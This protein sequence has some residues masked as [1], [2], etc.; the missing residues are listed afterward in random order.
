[1]PKTE[2]L[3][4]T[5][6]RGKISEIRNALQDLSLTLRTLAEFPGLVEPEENGA[7]YADNALLKAKYYSSKTGLLTVADD[8]G[9]EVN[10]INGR[11]G[12]LSARYGGPDATDEDRVNLLLGELKGAADRRA[13]FVC[14]MALEGSIRTVANGV[15]R[16]EIAEAALGEGGFGYDPIFIPDGYSETFGVLP[17][18]V[19]DRISH[20]AQCLKQVRNFL[21]IELGLR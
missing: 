11:P 3:I 7:T 14:V 21:E 20:R 5:A 19:K 8:S 2:L 9:L 4:G 1:M 12:V 13:Q 15:V 10:A 16:G 18:L 17:A 6:N